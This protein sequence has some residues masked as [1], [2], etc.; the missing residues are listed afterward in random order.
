MEMQ[1][2]NTGTLQS[3]NSLGLQVIHGRSSLSEEEDLRL[4]VKALLKQTDDSN[5]DMIAGLILSLIRQA[6][7]YVWA[8]TALAIISSAALTAALIMYLH[9]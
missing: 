3:R 9:R 6:S 4:K 5:Q 7:R 8:I 1:G 2:Q